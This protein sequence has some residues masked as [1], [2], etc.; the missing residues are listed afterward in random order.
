[1][2]IVVAVLIAN[3]VRALKSYV[4]QLRR[5]ASSP[6]DG[7][8]ADA[9][10]FDASETGSPHPASAGHSYDQGDPG[11]AGTHHGACDVGGH[12]GF[13]AG[14]GGFDIGGHH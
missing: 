13:D 9:F 2:I 12:S 8:A 11:C 4:A 14:H 3:A 1:M 6:A 5:D 7:E 10:L